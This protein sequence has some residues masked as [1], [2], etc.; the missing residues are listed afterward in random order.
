MFRSFAGL[1]R[2]PPHYRFLAIS[3]HP[4]NLREALEA[5][6]IVDA[7]LAGRSTPGRSPQRCRSSREPSSASS[8]SCFCR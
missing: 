7:K 4:R 6:R 8:R 3:D 1:R 2:V 5:T